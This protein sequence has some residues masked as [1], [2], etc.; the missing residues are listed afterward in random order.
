MTDH[1]G[2]LDEKLEHV[3]DALARD[4]GG[5]HNVVIVVHIRVLPV[6]RHIEALLVEVQDAL[7]Q[8]LLKL[9]LD[10]RLLPL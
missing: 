9:C 5:G 7:P 10:V 1:L 4:G 2:E 8:A 6:Q 3:G